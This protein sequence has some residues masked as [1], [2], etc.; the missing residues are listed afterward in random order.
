MRAHLQLL[1]FVLPLLATACSATPPTQ[2]P[3]QPTPAQQ[4]TIV[5]PETVINKTGPEELEHRFQQASVLLLREEF[6]A[7]AAEFETLA[8]IDP[9][10]DT[11][12]PSLYNAG[13]AY[14]GKG[15]LKKAAERFRASAKLNPQAPTAK[16]AWVRV[17]RMSAYLEQWDELELVAE[18]LLRRNDLSVLER[19][20]ALGA[21]ALSLVERGRVDDAYN[22][23]IVARNEIED[24][25]LGQA[26]TPPLELA[27]VAFALG[28]IRKAK[29]E[30]ILF[31]PMPKD[32]GAALED[33]C[34][35]LLDAQAAF[36]EAM[37]SVD[38]HWSAMAGYRVGQLYQ[39]LHRDVMKV[40]APTKTST[41]RS[42]QLWE[43]SMRLRY[44]VLLEK[45][46]KMMEGTVALG[47]RTGESSLWVTRAREAKTEL[48]NALAM[49]KEALSK[50]PFTEE[51]LKQALE[52][53]KAKKPKP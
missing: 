47:E 46:L 12:G 9:A 53:L 7:A 25:K 28:E 49:E 34:T 27:Q 44:R 40:P 51:E 45:G 20:E 3:G 37:R 39:N 14:A 38:A 19:I 16:I 22:V 42:R 4:P 10:A 6:D 5:V 23:I 15:E 41:L 18:E 1:S 43:G 31:A 36:T 33:R 50:L 35:G 26:G 11:A 8:K 13:M 52:E 2:S 30:K 21:K 17:S 32:F 48:E 24:R 29:S